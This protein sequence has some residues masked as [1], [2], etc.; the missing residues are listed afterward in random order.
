MLK[1][2]VFKTNIVVTGNQHQRILQAIPKMTASENIYNCIVRIE[3]IFATKN[4]PK[5]IWAG[6]LGQ[7]FTGNASEQYH[8]HVV[9]TYGFSTHDN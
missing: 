7:I 9:Q 6:A 2:D 8:L 4:I 1:F 5:D 3:R